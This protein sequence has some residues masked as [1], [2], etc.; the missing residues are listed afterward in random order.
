MPS[1]KHINMPFMV[2]SMS[3]GMDSAIVD[4]TNRDMMGVI[5]GTFA[6]MGN[7]DGC[8]E[9]IGGYR[10]DLFGVQKK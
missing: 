2:L 4:P 10:D 8:L 7:E 1:R 3:N 9:Y 6:L 5:Y